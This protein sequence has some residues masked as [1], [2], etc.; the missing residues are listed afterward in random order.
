MQ[1]TDHLKD[2]VANGYALAAL[3]APSFDAMS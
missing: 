2:A 3:N 1:F